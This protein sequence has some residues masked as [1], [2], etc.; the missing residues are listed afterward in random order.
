MNIL[1]ISYYLRFPFDNGASIAQFATLEYLSEV[2]NISL[3]LSENHSITDQNLSKLKKLF[4]KIKFHQ[5]EKKQLIEQKNQA[6]IV[7][8]RKS[9][10]RRFKAIFKYFIQT[11]KTN[12]NPEKISDEAYFFN[13]YSSYNPYFIHSQQFVEKIIEIIST[14]QIEVVQL[15]LVENLNLVT[16]IPSHVKKVFLQHESR[17]A[18][19]AS[20][21]SSKQIKSNATDYI[22]NINKHIKAA[23]LQEFDAIL[24]FN[25]SDTLILKNLVKKST[26]K[27]QCVTTPFPILEQ[28]FR[29]L[30]QEKF[31]KP[32][33]LIFV[34]G[35]EHFPNKD[36]VEWFIQEVSV[37]ILQKF[38]LTLQVIGNWN[39]T[40]TDQYKNHPSK[41]KFVG[42]VDDLYEFSKNS[43]SIAPVRIGGGLKTKVLMAMAQG[44]PVVATEFALTG[45]P[46]KHLEEVL[47]ANDKDKFIWSIEYLLQDLERTFL[48]SQNAQKFIKAGYSQAIVS[49]HRFDF[50]QNL[51]SEPS[52]PF[53]SCQ[54]NN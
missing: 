33:K 49:Q 34:G 32:D 13:F 3:L 17:L 1:I 31:Q 35:E 46:A 10:K 28:D 22:Y 54:C 4:P 2:C 30:S 42:F 27:I 21:I 25:D 24:T 18:K 43:I 29:E 37:D 36:A 41:V 14:D 53:E 19:I 40:T 23:F 39:K 38:G 8:I 6:K 5:L 11:I 9:I 51:L 15:E 52:I 47:I 50:Y 26:K 48:L 7:K 45:I 16:V 44:I 12:R 20:H